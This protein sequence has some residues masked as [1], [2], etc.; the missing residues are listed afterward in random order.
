M[1]DP[2]NDCAYPGERPSATILLDEVGPARSA[3]WSPFTSI[4]LSPMPC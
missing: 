1:N 4:G 2:R 3:H